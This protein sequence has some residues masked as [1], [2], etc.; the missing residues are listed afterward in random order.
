MA[1]ALAWW[2]AGSSQRAIAAPSLAGLP[3]DNYDGDD[4][5]ARIA[6]GSTWSD[7]E[8]A[9]LEETTRRAG[10]PP[11]ASEKDAASLSRRLPEC[12]GTKQVAEPI[13]K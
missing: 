9:L 2:L 11:C 5:T 12:V 4:A 7:Q 8:R 10:D 13:P 1:V 3:F 6:N